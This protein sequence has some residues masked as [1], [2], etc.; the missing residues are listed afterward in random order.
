MLG[1]KMKKIKSVEVPR[2]LRRLHGEEGV[3][4]KCS[5]LRTAACV[6]PKEGVLVLSWMVQ[7]QGAIQTL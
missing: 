4:G 7:T 1:K 3:L 2:P 5:L 6:V